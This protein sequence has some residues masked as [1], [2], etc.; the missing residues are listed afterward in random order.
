M[1]TTENDFWRIF[2]E[3]EAR[4]DRFPNPNRLLLILTLIF[5]AAFGESSVNKAVPPVILTLIT[6]KMCEITDSIAH[7]CTDMLGTLLSKTE[8]QNDNRCS[9]PSRHKKTKLK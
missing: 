6:D 8:T 2:L 9:Y 4:V 7:F 1:Y 5:P 3:A